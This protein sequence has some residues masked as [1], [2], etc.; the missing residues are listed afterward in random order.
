[1]RRLTG[2]L[3]RKGYP[4]G[5]AYRVV[6]EALEQEGIDPAAAGLDTEAVLDA[7]ADGLDGLDSL[8]G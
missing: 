3:A 8:D 1:V 4:P 6:R 2:L 7:D 5:L